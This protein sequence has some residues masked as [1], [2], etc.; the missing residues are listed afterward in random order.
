MITTPR[1]DARLAAAV[2]DHAEIDALRADCSAALANL[3]SQLNAAQ[4]QVQTL[5]AQLAGEISQ[6][7]ADQAQITTLTAQLAAVNSQVAGL[8]A[9]VTTL[10]TNLTA[11]QAALTACQ[12][13]LA[14][15]EAILH[16]PPPPPAPH[17]A[18]LPMVNSGWFGSWYRP[19]WANY[20]T[21]FGRAITSCQQT[22]IDQNQTSWVAFEGSAN[23]LLGQAPLD[24]IRPTKVFLR[25]NPGI[26]KPGMNLPQQTVSSY[27]DINS[28]AQDAMF[29]RIFASIAAMNLAD[30]NLCINQEGTGDWFVG[31]SKFDQAGSI[32]AFRRLAAQA[33]LLIPGVKIWYDISLGVEF[34]AAYPGD[35][36]VDGVLADGY[37]RRAEGWW[38][39]EGA[40]GFGA[41]KAFCEAHSKPWYAGE[42]GTQDSRD[43]QG[44]I[45][46]VWRYLTEPGSRA[47]EGTPA[48]W[49]SDSAYDSALG[50]NPLTAAY[51]LTKFGG[52]NP[53]AWVPP[54]PP[55]SGTSLVHFYGWP[56]GGIP[57]P[58]F[59]LFVGGTSYG[60]K[61]IPGDASGGVVDW[62]I[63]VTLAAGAQ[64]TLKMIGGNWYTVDTVT[65]TPGGTKVLRTQLGPGGG[66]NW[67]L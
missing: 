55:P 14:A 17:G 39:P 41:L 65:C 7:T 20:Q 46:L 50:H 45:N 23:Y 16:P 54:P 48:W 51:L 15:D 5:Q 61:T 10:Q 66:V 12:A 49:D 18:P 56:A 8:Q 30:P 21:I 31:S 4:A 47:I 24:L 27:Q 58:V 38:Q 37:D 63:P 62:S 53:A 29:G 13:A 36:Y 40:N 59:E 34:A 64:L 2:D 57:T 33:R 6:E 1:A 42:I 19:M 67:T 60:Q 3:Q 52:L 9:Q 25:F 26:L 43:Y 44:W 11:S 35:A 28:G 22:F 32:A